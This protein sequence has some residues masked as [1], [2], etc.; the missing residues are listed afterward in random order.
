MK[1]NV[2]EMKLMNRKGGIRINSSKIYDEES[3]GKQEK[4]DFVDSM[5]DGKL[6]Y[7]LTLF[8][9]FN[10]DKK[11]MPKNDNWGDVKTVSLKAWLKRND[12]R[13]LFDNWFRYGKI[14]LLSC[15][16]FIQRQKV[17]RY[18]TYEDF[19]DEVFHKQMI[20]CENLERKYFREH[21]EYSI[22]QNEIQNNINKIWLGTNISVSSRDGIKAYEEKL[23][24]EDLKFIKEKYD[25]INKVISDESDEIDN[26]FMK[27]EE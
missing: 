12:E 11:T 19:T 8:K 6:S 5:Q 3:I 1:W 26:Y 27:Y 10:E 15:E 16:V 4:I 9:K 14:S 23:S 22:L 17:T 7:I 25:Y 20:E 18:N 21:D 13:E 2:E 24:I